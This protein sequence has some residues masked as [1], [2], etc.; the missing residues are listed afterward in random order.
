MLVRRS[1]RGAYIGSS[2]PVTSRPASAL[3]SLY[4]GHRSATPAPDR[5][6]AGRATCPRFADQGHRRHREEQLRAPGARR[7]TTWTR[8]ERPRHARRSR[9]PRPSR[10]SQT[11]KLLLYDVYLRND[12]RRVSA[13]DYRSP[14]STA[15]RCRRRRHYRARSHREGPIHPSAFRRRV[16]RHPG[17]AARRR[18]CASASTSCAATSSVARYGVWSLHHGDIRLLRGGRRTSG[19][20]TRRADLRRDPADLRKSWTPVSCSQ[21]LFPT[22]PGF[23]VARKPSPTPIV[24]RRPW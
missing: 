23:S 2:A 13:E 22:T 1:T 19:S 11:R 8:R 18:P 4:R 17:Q 7:S 3:R 5:T 20:S 14:P 21:G 15:R 24:A 6:P 16:S 12:A 10:N 9:P